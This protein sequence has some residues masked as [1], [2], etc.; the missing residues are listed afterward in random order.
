MFGKEEKPKHPRRIRLTEEK[1]TIDGEIVEEVW[2]KTRVGIALIVFGSI[3]LAGIV[4]LRYFWPGNENRDVLSTQTEIENEPTPKI[5]T[6]KD[7]ET[8]IQN[9]K[10]SLENITEENVISSQAAIQKIIQDLGSLQQ[11]SKSSTNVFCQMVCKE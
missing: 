7:V 3:I 10:E 11:G 1:E 8:V 9:A 5:P 6:K 2:S 4:G